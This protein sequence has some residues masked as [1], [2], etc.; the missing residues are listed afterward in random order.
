M[1]P[2]PEPRQRR[3]RRK[4]RRPGQF[5]C[6]A[7]GIALAQHPARGTDR[8]P[9]SE[10]A[11][12]SKTLA[13]IAYQ[14]VP[15]ALFSVPEMESNDV[16]DAPAQLTVSPGV[17][18][19]VVSIV[20]QG[21]WD[22]DEASLERCLENEIQVLGSAKGWME[23][24]DPQEG[25]AADHHVRQD[26]AGRTPQDVVHVSDGV[27][28]RCLDLITTCI[29]RSHPAV[30][31]NCAFVRQQRLDLPL[32]PVRMPAVVVVEEDEKVSRRAPHTV[33][34]GDRHTGVGLVK[35]G[36]SRKRI[37]DSSERL[38]VLGAVVDQHDLDLVVGLAGDGVECLCEVGPSSVGRND[39][40]DER[41]GTLTRRVDL[42]HDDSLWAADNSGLHDCAGGSLST[43]RMGLDFAH[44]GGFA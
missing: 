32:D 18:A 19:S 6:S 30:R 13:M 16:I 12:G 24:T 25:L 41:K 44:T 35:N 42:M 26:D 3:T 23:P 28:V 5:D 40:T 15:P 22:K 21:F 14:I 33:V 17:V 10:P 43:C 27:L 7:D 2:F 37:G 9:C 4:A 20:D 8:A 38:D 34:P 31:H 1:S 29:D 39:D 11:I 36:D